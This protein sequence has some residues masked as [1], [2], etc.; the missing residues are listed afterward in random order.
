MVTYVSVHRNETLEPSEFVAQMASKQLI[1]TW[2]LDHK[3]VKYC[4]ILD[5]ERPKWLKITQN[6]PRKP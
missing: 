2:F 5:F 6:L 3:T 4:L 1:L